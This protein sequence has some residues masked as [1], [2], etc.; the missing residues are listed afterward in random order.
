MI[1]TED[2]AGPRTQGKLQGANRINR[3]VETEKECGIISFPHCSWAWS[4]ELR[5]LLQGLQVASGSAP[6][7]FSIP[8]ISTN[9]CWH[10]NIWLGGG[11]LGMQ[12]P[13]WILL[14]WESSGLS[15]SNLRF[16]FFG[17]LQPIFSHLDFLLMPSWGWG[18]G[19]T[20]ERGEAEM[21]LMGGAL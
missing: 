3:V 12:H 8:S 10:I 6:Y 19:L 1:R 15:T 18:R 21:A 7:S 11:I 9:N 20:S 17:S 4:D 16:F 2:G 13:I 5:S 14:S